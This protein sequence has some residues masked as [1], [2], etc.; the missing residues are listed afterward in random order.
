MGFVDG[1]KY[2]IKGLLFLASR[3]TLWK[4]ALLPVIVSLLSYQFI[5]NLGKQ[6][7]AFYKHNLV[8]KIANHLPRIL[9][10]LIYGLDISVIFFLLFLGVIVFIIVNFL[11]SPAQ[12]LLSRKVEEMHLGTVLPG[13][14]KRSV[15]VSIVV[16]ILGKLNYFFDLLIVTLLLFVVNFIPLLGQ[17]ASLAV[18]SYYSAAWFMGPTLDRKQLS[19]KQRKQKIKAYTPL[20]I[21]FGFACFLSFF[22]P[23]FTFPGISIAA[24][25][26]Q[27]ISISASVFAI[28]VNIVGGT[29][30]AVDKIL[31]QK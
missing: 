24:F 9:E 16:G 21:G 4:Y 11:S 15:I 29:L 5:L 1:M 31:S 17:L 3:I 20:V 14:P 18:I 26:I 6:A 19:Y 27:E 25:K 22:I 12:R 8:A 10:F 23:P 7:Y 28:P 13:M 30:L 2:Y